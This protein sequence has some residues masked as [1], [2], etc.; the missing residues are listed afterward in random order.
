MNLEK[1]GCIVLS[2]RPLKN[3]V[4]ICIKGPRFFLSSWDRFLISGLVFSIPAC[5]VLNKVVI[6]TTCVACIYTVF[7]TRIRDDS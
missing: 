5:M 4:E 1:C 6:Y 3:I 7:N 2:S